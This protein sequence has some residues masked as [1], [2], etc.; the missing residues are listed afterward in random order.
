MTAS[1][2]EA[3][4][5]GRLGERL[6]AAG[7]LAP[8]E[9]A[10]ALA[11]QRRAHRPL[12]QILVALGFVDEEQVARLRA[13]DLGLAFLGAGELAPD[14]ALCAELEP[15]FVARTGALPLGRTEHGTRVALV[16]PD[17]PER[18]ADVRA[19]FTGELELVL[20]TP[21]ALRRA[22]NDVFASEARATARLLD[23]AVR[24]GATDLHVEPDAHVGRVRMRVDGI[25]R[26]G[27][28]VPRELCLPVVTRLKILAGLDIAE[29]RKPQDGRIRAVVDGGDVDLR[30][31]ILPCADGENAV[32]R[33]LD[34]RNTALTLMDLG[35]SPRQTEL[36]ARVA[37]RPH[38]LFLVTGPTGAGKTTTLYALLSEVDALARNV[39][40]VEDPIEYRLPLARQTQVDPAAGLDFTAGLRAILRQDPDVILV[41]EIRDEETARMAV[42]AALTGHLVLA[43]LHANSAL[44]AAPRLFDLGVDARH[45]D[46]ALVGVLGQR[47]VRRNCAACACAAE[48]DVKERAWLGGDLGSPRSARGCSRCAWT[49]FRGR[50]ALAE[51][52]LPD[53]RCAAVLRAGGS[54]AELAEA[55]AR[56]GF[57]PIAEEARRLVRAGVTPRAEIERVCRSQRL[58]EDE[59]A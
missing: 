37:E 7:C 6:V 33:I 56:A 5:R 19:R 12:G 30:V 39:V 25:L 4:A 8:E 20:T 47:L 14:A 3:P 28:S 43:T 11:E 49:G 35:L 24:A 21:A 34:R 17:D 15:D 46:D 31:S 1:H 53:E 32:V 36:L 18:L 13:E 52:F 58:Q 45:V 10:L 41:G 42:R 54:A 48:L 27:E 59:R 55:A 29:R 16:E 23:D 22:A 26:A 9:L 57:V 2:R 44:G 50:T 51:L 40:T 38:G